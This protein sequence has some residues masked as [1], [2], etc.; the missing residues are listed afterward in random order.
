[1]IKLENYFLY[2]SSQFELKIE[3]LTIQD[4]SRF[5]IVG[6][7][8]SGKTTLMK[9]LAGLHNNYQGTLQINGKTISARGLSALY[10]YNIMF[11]TQDL[12]LWPHMSASEH[13]SFVLS[14]GV[15]LQSDAAE[16]WLDIVGLKNKQNVKPHELSGGEQ[17]RLALARVLSAKP[18]Y[19]FLDEPFANIDPVLACEL[20]KQIDREYKKQNFALIEVTH[21]YLGIDDE[22]TTILVVIDGKIVQQGNWQKISQH[23]NNEWTKKWVKLAT[24]NL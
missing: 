7:S 24:R 23:P 12:G 18:K 8:G 13:I 1:M 11:L 19:L 6:P 3:C 14:K 2:I 22:K 21:Y 17:K 10:E 20:M 9:S 15:S 4:S 16:Y 5:F